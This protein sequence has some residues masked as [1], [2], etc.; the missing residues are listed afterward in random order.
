M[1]LVWEFFRVECGGGVLSP[2][3]IMR[4]LVAEL[5][6]PAKSRFIGARPRQATAGRAVKTRQNPKQF[7]YHL[8]TD[9]I[10]SKPRFL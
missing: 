6:E 4:P 9:L 5:V 7:E 1:F 10:I 8:L 2:P 3:E